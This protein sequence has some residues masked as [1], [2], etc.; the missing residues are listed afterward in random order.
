MK[1]TSICISLFASLLSTVSPLS[2][3]ILLD[4]TFTDLNYTNGSDPNDSQWRIH[5]NSA[6]GTKSA[7]SGKLVIGRATTDGNGFNPGAVTT[8][9]STT[10]S[11]G[12]TIVLTFDATITGGTAAPDNFRFGLF[13]SGGTNLTGDL[14]GNPPATSTTF[15][16]DVGY[17][18]FVPQH[19]T[20]TG[21]LRYRGTTTA[22]NAIQLTGTAN[23]SFSTSTISS[24]SASG[25]PFSGSLSITRSATNSYDL[26]A[27]FAGNTLATTSYSPALDTS[28]FDSL[29]FFSV[30]NQANM[31]LTLDNVKVEVVPEPSSILLLG[32]ASATLI[33]RR[34]RH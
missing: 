21:S 22:S 12:Q 8:F 20:G 24:A 28:T 1:H 29:S 5:T 11:V 19:T 30:M 26:S 13:N 34:R 10:L 16:N 7:G 6:T 25:T 3:A 27:T 23:L 31:S 32:L 9:T 33:T 18:V 4:D 17:S 14:V 2:G 15:H